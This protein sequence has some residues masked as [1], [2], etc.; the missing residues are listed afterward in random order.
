M[1]RI[2]LVFLSFT[3]AILVAA[4]GGSGTS[5]SQAPAP[6]TLFAVNDIHGYISPSDTSAGISPATRVFT[7]TNAAGVTVKAG[8]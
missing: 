1:G 8:A 2:R 5:S 7:S 3:T 4:C 6:V